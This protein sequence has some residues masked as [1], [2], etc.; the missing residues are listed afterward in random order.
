MMSPK[1]AEQP[2]R[3]ERELEIALFRY[4]LIA[5]LIHDPP[6]AGQQEKLLREIAGKPYRIPYSKRMR[7]GITTL[8]R[9]LKSYQEGGFDALRPTRRSDHGKSRAFPEAVLQRAIE[10][11][12][13]HPGRTTSMLVQLLKRDPGIEL[14]Q[15]VNTHTLTTHLRQHGKTRRLLSEKAREKPFVRFEREHANSLW[16]GDEMHGPWLPDPAVDG[17]KRRAYLFCFLDDHSR[18]VPYAEFFWDEALPRMERVLRIGILRR[19]VPQA[20]Y[21]DNGYGQ[22]VIM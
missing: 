16:Q 2:D 6:D 20:I 3:Y 9:Y 21:V 19:G 4:G 14:E 11:R 5:Q 8:R 1:K 22:L 18:L 10:L 7:V 12:E 13:E 15:P 17:R